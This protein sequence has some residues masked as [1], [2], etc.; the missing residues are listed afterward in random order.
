MTR[1]PEQVPLRRNYSGMV[2]IRYIEANAASDGKYWPRGRDWDPPSEVTQADGVKR[3]HWRKAQVHCERTVSEALEAY[4]HGKN[5]ISQVPRAGCCLLVP[6]ILRPRIER[7]KWTRR[8]QEINSDPYS[9]RRR[10]WPDA[11]LGVKRRLSG[12]TVKLI[13]A[14]H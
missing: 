4:S 5:G 8:G 6:G 14:I 13:N 3:F 7:G 11:Q 1:S 9:C 12:Q 10:A 2:P